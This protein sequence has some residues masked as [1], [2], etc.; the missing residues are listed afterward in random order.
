MT[1]RSP[2]LALMFA[3]LVCGTTVAKADFLS[4]LSYQT[5]SFQPKSVL[6][7]IVPE[8]ATAP[9]GETLLAACEVGA[10][11]VVTLRLWFFNPAGALVAGP[12]TVTTVGTMAGMKVGAGPGSFA[13]AFDV[14]GNPTD[15][16]G[17]GIYFRSYTLS[18]VQISGPIDTRVNSLTNLDE[19]L[20]AVAGYPTATGTGFV[21]TWVRN[22]LT[23]GTPTS[24][25]YA[26]RFTASG[27]A[28]DVADVRIDATTVNNINAPQVA[29]WPNGRFVVS[30]MDGLPFPATGTLGSGTGVFARVMNAAFTFRTGQ[31]TIPVTTLDDQFQPFVAC[32]YNQT[33]VCAWSSFVTGGFDAFAR[34]FND[35]GVA[36]DATDIDLSSTAA[37]N[38]HVVTGLSMCASGDWCATMDAAGPS[39][40]FFAP[41]S[42][43]I[44]LTSNGATASVIE[45][46]FLDP[47]TS[48]ET[49]LN[50]RVK[51]DQ[52]GHA[53][54]G[55]AI[56]TGTS[57][58]LIGF[59]ALRS[60]LQFDSVAPPAG[61][62]V[63]VY[64]D[65]PGS[66]SA[67]YILGCSFGTGPIAV[68]NRKLPLSPDQLLL[69]CLSGVYPT[70]FTNFVGTLDAFGG[71][72]GAQVVIPNLPILVGLTFYFAYGVIDPSWP[73]SVRATSPAASFTV[74]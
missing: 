67:S 39:A 25:V 13:V 55:F 46:G 56:D 58:G 34:R 26:R 69:D 38:G 68:D 52:F 29:T 1:K 65:S 43:F 4:F 66:P 2:N 72:S 61:A 70:V 21:F 10:N 19:R 5:L 9:T 6:T 49:Q 37:T 24:G 32:D 71:A 18:G 3:L 7:L 20:P 45:D 33:F 64:L 74:Q 41:R 17:H 51:L 16:N 73:S 40:G 15:T 63:T 8:M 11:N 36:L 12:T 47:A 53:S 30:W 28:I 60:M 27:V 22:G 14:V 31:L 35:L 62:T 23:P 44:R 48:S 57:V 54:F 50:A 42:K 59:K